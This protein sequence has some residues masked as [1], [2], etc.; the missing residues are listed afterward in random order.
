MGTVLIEVVVGWSP[1][2]VAAIVGGTL[3]VLTKCLTMEE[4]YRYINWPAVFLIATMLPLGIAMENSGATQFLTEKMMRLIGDFGPLA[5][6]T[7]LFLFSV[8]ASQVIPNAAVVVL[9]APIAISTAVAMDVSPQSFMMA[10]A[11]AASA[12]FLSPVSHPANVLVMGPG[13]YKFTDY[14]KVGFPLTVL[15]LLVTLIVLPVVWPFR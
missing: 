12:S 1:I 4:A 6:L 9:M 10:I 5:V 13:G 2:A 11:I 14:L 15:V 7:G 8:L 3:M